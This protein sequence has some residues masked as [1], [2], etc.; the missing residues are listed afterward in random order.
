MTWF[1]DSLKILV[2]PRAKALAEKKSHTMFHR[3]RQAKFD[4]SGVMLSSSQ[5]FILLQLPQKI[6]LAS[7]VVKIDSK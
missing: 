1:G 5:F 7:K 6:K 4:N 2:P 3:F